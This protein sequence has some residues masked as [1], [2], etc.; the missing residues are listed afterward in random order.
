MKQFN[1]EILESLVNHFY[2]NRFALVGYVV[3]KLLNKDVDCSDIPMSVNKMTVFGYFLSTYPT[4]IKAMESVDEYDLVS[5]LKIINIIKIMKHITLSKWTNKEKN[6]LNYDKKVYK[7][8]GLYKS[9]VGDATKGSGNV[10]V[11]VKTRSK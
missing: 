4:L 5:R 8:Y 9:I 2:S 1:D 10:C 11:G 3:H 7:N 6:K